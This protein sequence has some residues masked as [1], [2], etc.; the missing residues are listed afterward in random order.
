MG[1]IAAGIVISRFFSNNSASRRT[2]ERIEVTAAEAVPVPP[3]PAPQTSSLQSDDE[4]A[5]GILKPESPGIVRECFESLS[6]LTDSDLETIGELRDRFLSSDPLW[7]QVEDMELAWRTIEFTTPEK[8]FRQARIE[9]ISSSRGFAYRAELSHAESETQSV[10]K[11]LKEKANLTLDEANETARTWTSEKPDTQ[12]LGVVSSFR[13][14]WRNGR[15]LS[16]MVNGPNDVARPLSIR[17]RD[18]AN[19]V[20]CVVEDSTARADC[21]C[22]KKADP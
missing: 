22:L 14:F 8:E 12:I 3:P 2:E 5:F 11:P 6:Q 10:L 20:Q 18:G 15:E 16:L 21:E 7:G 4:K 19:E 9:R 17:I 13:Y 1:L